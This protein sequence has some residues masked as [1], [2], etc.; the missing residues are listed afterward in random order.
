SIGAERLSVTPDA[1]TVQELIPELDISL[2]NGLFVHKD[3]PQDVRDKI[4]A[5]AKKTVLSD[6]AQELAAQTG[7]LVYWQDADSVAKQIANDK[8][9][10]QAITSA[11]AE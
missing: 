9:S 11:L 8:L 3:T 2:W 10:F 5:V 1:P 4:I 7:A 6:R